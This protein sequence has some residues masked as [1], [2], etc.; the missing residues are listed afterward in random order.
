[1]HRL[2]EKDLIAW[3]KQA[4]IK[5]L[6]VRGARQVGKSYLV[7]KFGKE[8]FSSMVV[9]NFE[10]ERKYKTYFATLDPNKIVSSISTMSGQAIKPG[11]TLLF[12]DEIQECPDAILAL[13]YFK[14]KMS[15]LHVIAAGS[16][17]EFTLNKPKFRMPVSRVQSLYV[18]P[19]SFNEFLAAIG[20]HKLLDYLAEIEL[21]ECIDGGI[22]ETLIENLRE[23]FFIGGM[24]E[25]VAHYSEN[26]DLFQCQSL[27]AALL[28]YYQ[29]DFGKYDR[30]VNI[31]YLQTYL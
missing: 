16:L 15:N 3:K 23:Y 13:R 1:M 26:K 30:S 17:L 14:E 11:E 29:K 21:G 5:P 10:F 7:E 9:V 6:L 8:H 28:E 12:L 22:Q 24:P 27:Q 4:K 25:V 31:R 2:V 18:K 19:C 20:H